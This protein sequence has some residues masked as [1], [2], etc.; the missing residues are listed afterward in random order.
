MKDLSIK[1][2]ILVLIIGSL[3][4]LSTSVAVMSVFSTKDALVKTSYDRLTSAR[5]SK[6]EQLNKFF[7]QKIKEIKVLATSE[8]IDYMVNDLIFVH[9][10]LKVK[11]NESYPVDNPLAIEKTAP[12][13]KFFKNFLNDYGYYDILI[14]CAKHGHIMYTQAK[15]SDYGENVGSGYLSNSGIGEVWRK[16]KELKRP[17]F[18]DMRPYQ[19]SNNAPAMFLGTPIYTDGEF[20]SVLVFQISEKE[21]DN[22]MHFRAGYGK[23]Q[24]DYLVGADKLMRS[25]SYLDPKNHS[26]VAS[27][28]NPTTGMVDTEAT[29]S[30][31]KGE[32]DTKVVVDYNGNSV[33]SAYSTVKVKDDFSWV[34]LS[35][36]DEAEVMQTPNS[37]RNKIVITT[38]VLMVLVVLLTIFVIKRSILKPLDDFQNGL[39]EFFKYL[40]RETLEV[41]MLDDSNNDEMGSMAKLINKNIEITKQA[42]QESTEL[43][44][45]TSRVIG[46]MNQGYLNSR[47]QKDAKD[48]TLVEL[49]KLI[50]SMLDNMELQIG[51]DINKINKHF[52]K[53]QKMEFGSTIENPKGN[54]EKI[55][56]LLSTQS[57]IIINDVA[58][59]LSRLKDGDLTARV[60]IDYKGDFIEIKNSINSFA[61]TVE[62][63]ISDINGS[64][65]Q[66]STA[67]NEINTAAQSLSQGAMQQASSL[68]ETTAAIEEMAGG[69]SQNADNARK[70]NEISTKSSS[71]AKDGGEAVEQT[72]EAMRNIADKI[73]IIEDIAY[74]TNLLALNAAIEAARAGENGKGFAVVASEVKKLAERSKTAA[75][76]ISQITIQSVEISEKAGSLLNSIVPSIEQTA[77]LIEEISSASAEQDTGI[78]QINYAMTSLDQVTQQNASAS[79]ELASAS[80]EMNSQATHLKKLISFF[81]V[82]STQQATTNVFKSETTTQPTQTASVKEDSDF[83]QF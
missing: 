64:V 26:I 58:K 37:I 50:N 79:E 68:E 57:D 43:I 54:I 30:A 83:V 7:E 11:S 27:F 73:S 5:D 33:L 9:E 72:V 66:M 35:E 6:I 28:A 78:T 44:E 63:V 80:Q 25:D 22:I 4:V 55:A 16:V 71:M 74:Q 45:D 18:V 61:S 32:K 36:I 76:E 62:S 29:K 65:L 51:S 8:D 69:I 70:T 31:L 17:V 48:P 75:Q 19:P 67:S 21:I 20:K 10:E 34:I 2:K 53:L 13:E 24:K 41:K 49:K 14:I 81:K 42:I 56:N 39:S 40:N 23:T 15:E 47:I 82:D 59:V 38:L 1:V 12:H 46:D 52:E 3:L 60:E 77:E